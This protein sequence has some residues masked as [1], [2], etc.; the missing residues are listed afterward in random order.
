MLSTYSIIKYPIEPPETKY[1]WLTIDKKWR[2]NAE[3]DLSHLTRLCV[4]EVPAEVSS[5][6]PSTKKI[7]HQTPNKRKPL[8]HAD[9]YH[10]P[11]EP[12][13]LA[14]G[15]HGRRRWPAPRPGSNPQLTHQVA[16]RGHPSSPGSGRPIIHARQAPNHTKPT[17]QIRRRR[18]LRSARRAS[19][20]ALIVV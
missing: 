20:G 16:P 12:S 10:P 3:S 5:Q 4:W 6:T 1:C 18:P 2:I 14:C 13:H 15:G 19:K 17:N 7:K 8:I 11:N 9:A